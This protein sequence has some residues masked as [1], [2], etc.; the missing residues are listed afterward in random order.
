VVAALACHGFLATVLPGRLVE[1]EYEGGEL[2]LV[3]GTVA[4]MVGVGSEKKIK[5]HLNSALG[6]MGDGDGEDDSGRTL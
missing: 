3:I 2:G 1:N 4:G 6:H 5:S